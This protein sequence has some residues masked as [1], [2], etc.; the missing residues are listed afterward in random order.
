MELQQLPGNHQDE[1]CLSLQL[2]EPVAVALLW[3]KKLP[4]NHIKATIQYPRTKFAEIMRIQGNK[5]QKIQDHQAAHQIKT[6]VSIHSV[7]LVFST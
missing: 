2:E 4:K 1:M 7:P 6:Q 3:P 5:I